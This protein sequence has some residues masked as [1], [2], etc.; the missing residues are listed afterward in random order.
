MHNERIIIAGFG[1]QGIL[2]MGQLLAQAA[3]DEGRQVTWL[4]SYGPAMRGGTANCN[5]IVDDAPIASPV[6]HGDATSVLIMNVP[7]MKFVADLVP[8][9]FALINTSM[10]NTRVERTDVRAFYVPAT[11]LAVAAGDLK[12]TNLV[13]LGAFTEM[14]HCVGSASVLHALEAKLGGAK[15]HLMDANRRAFALGAEAIAAQEG[16]AHRPTEPSVPR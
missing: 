9:G 7:S 5:V 4:P 2:T 8:G 15:A 1:G 14:T 10:V 13:M 3:L 16:A 6:V 11:E 12:T